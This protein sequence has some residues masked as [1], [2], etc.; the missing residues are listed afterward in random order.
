MFKNW[1]VF[2]T[3]PNHEH[4]GTKEDVDILDPIGCGY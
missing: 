1:Y 2:E 4:H 3:A